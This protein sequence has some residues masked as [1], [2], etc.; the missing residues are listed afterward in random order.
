MRIPLCSSTIFLVL[1]TLGFAHQALE[2]SIAEA[3]NG[4]VDR[5]PR[6][7]PRPIENSLD[8]RLLRPRSVGGDLGKRFPPPQS[9]PLGSLAKR[10]PRP[11]SR[12]NRDSTNNRRA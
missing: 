4:I 1:V 5:V 2:E 9:R 3:E 10:L 6:P 7:Q 12:L 11:Q 8:K